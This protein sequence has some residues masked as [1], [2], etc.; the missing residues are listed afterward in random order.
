[1]SLQPLVGL[2]SR[3]ALNIFLLIGRFFAAVGIQEE[4]SAFGIV[5]LIPDGALRIERG[6]DIDHAF[7]RRGRGLKRLVSSL[8]QGRRAVNRTACRGQRHIRKRKTKKDRDSRPAFFVAGQQGQI[9]KRSLD[10]AN[11]TLPD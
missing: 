3:H 11:A 4:F 5:I 2:R 6:N 1:M 10:T 9:K 8:I 7:F